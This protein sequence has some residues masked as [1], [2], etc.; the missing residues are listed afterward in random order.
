MC[1]HMCIWLSYM[2][3]LKY[4]NYF[5]RSRM[6]VPSITWSFEVLCFIIDLQPYNPPPSGKIG[7]IYKKKSDPSGDPSLDFIIIM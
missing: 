7:F 4:K 2:I 1:L 3:S 5:Y 6:K